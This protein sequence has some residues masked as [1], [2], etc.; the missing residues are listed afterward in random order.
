MTKLIGKDLKDSAFSIGRLLIWAV[1]IYGLIGVVTMAVLAY[2]GKT[3]A[4][5][6]Q[7]ST[8]VC[9]GAIIGRI[10]RGKK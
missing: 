8:M 4:P 7:S 2:Q 3:I 6:V 9:I 5:Q 1:G 10:E